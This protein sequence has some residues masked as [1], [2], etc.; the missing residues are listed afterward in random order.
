[1]IVG[2]P[3]RWPKFIKSEGEKSREGLDGITEIEGDQLELPGSKPPGRSPEQ[4]HRLT[5]ASFRF[6][7]D[8]ASFTLHFV[9][10]GVMDRHAPTKRGKDLPP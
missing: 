6:L 5:F 9:A 1:M 10:T 7:A 4:G 2:A 3:N 8:V